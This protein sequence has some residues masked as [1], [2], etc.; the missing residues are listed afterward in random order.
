VA[1]WAFAEENFDFLALLTNANQRSLLEKS[2]QTSYPAGSVAVAQGDLGR[3]FLLRRGLVRI[4]WTAPDGRETTITF[5]Y[6]G[7]LV[8]APLLVPGPAGTW[9]FPGSVAAQIVVDSTLTFL[10]L[11]TVR[12]LAA[13]EIEVVTAIA[14]CLAARVVRDIRKVAVGSLGNVPERLAVDLLE[15]AT[16]TQLSQGRLEAKATHQ[17]LA[18]SIGSSREV[19]SRALKAL[20]AQKIVETGPR[21]TRILDPVRLAMTVRTYVA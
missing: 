19:V 10:D 17:E 21:L 6:P 11:E 1:T 16:R 5:M 3:A 15:R 9:G 18:D 14:S 8:G 13:R 12:R 20:R 4:Y 7:D 2:K